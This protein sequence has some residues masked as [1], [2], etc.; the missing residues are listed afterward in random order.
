MERFIYGPKLIMEFIDIR[1]GDIV[2]TMLSNNILLSSL[3]YVYY[4]GTYI[5]M[6]ILLLIDRYYYSQDYIF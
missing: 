3:L 2:I 1:I 4:K 5:N 6:F